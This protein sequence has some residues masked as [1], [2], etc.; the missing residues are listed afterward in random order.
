MKIHYLQHVPFENSGNIENWAIKNGFILS[1]TKLYEENSFPET[2]DFDFLIILGGPMNI[3]EEDK[4][5][6]LKKEKEFIKKAIESNKKVLGICLGAQLIADVLGAKVY[7]NPHKEIGWYP[8]KFSKDAQNIYLFNNLPEELSVIHWHGDTFNIPKESISIGSSEACK[9]QGFIYKN[10]V[11][12]L[13]FHLETSVESLNNLIEN[14]K[15]EII[16][17]KFIQTPEKMLLQKENFV[18]LERN[19]YNFLDNL[20]DCSD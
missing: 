18:E 15:D 11:I 1:C 16:K 7:K 4:Y 12:G 14:C 17:D 3:Y 2:E 13:Q 20:I 5:L 6:W 19:L 8:V 9:N 10:K